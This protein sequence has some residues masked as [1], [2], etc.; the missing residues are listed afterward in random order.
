MTSG[1]LVVESY[2]S[3]YRKYRERYGLRRPVYGM[4]RLDVEPE[5]SS[6]RYRGIDRD[7]LVANDFKPRNL[8]ELF[9]DDLRQKGALPEG[10]DFVPFEHLA[11]VH[12]YLEHTEQNYE[13][14]FVRIVDS[15]STIPD[16]YASIGF[17]PSYFYSDHF[18]ASCDCMLFPRWHG[19]DMEGVLFREHF[20]KLSIYGTFSEPREASEFLKYYLS[21]DWTETGDYFVTEVAV[22]K[23]NL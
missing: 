1:F 21:F 20:E 18:S 2:E 8:A 10:E 23:E 6:V 5:Q 3:L 14:I 11:E 15:E 16:G 4:P 17:E 19:T 7:C 22:Q 13:T 9:L 12:K